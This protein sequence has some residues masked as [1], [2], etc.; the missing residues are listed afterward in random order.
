M[1]KKYTVIV[2][3]PP[4]EFGDKLSMS[5]VARGADANYSTMTI[6]QIKA[7][8]VNNIADPNGAILA[9]WVPSSLLQEGM[10]IMKAYGFN[11]KQSYIWIK[12]TKEPF[13][14]L[15]KQVVLDVKSKKG[16]ILRDALKQTILQFNFNGMFGFGMGRLF[17]QSHEVCL[18]GTNNNKIYKKLLNKSQRSVCFAPNL[19]HSA[20]PEH[21]QD[22]LDKM[23][24]GNK[25]SKIE[26]FSRRQRKNW[27][28]IGN[29]SV[30]TKNEDILVSLKKV[31]NLSEN[32]MFSINKIVSCYDEDKREDLFKM[33][34]KVP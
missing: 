1:N 15:I 18:I 27:I 7:L 31:I 4:Y 6:S 32:D 10:D 25:C 20:K 23:F 29:E 21:L 19:K 3:D 2:I 12:S 13:K 14:K 17:R 22:A 9:L 11:Q 33:W 28:C 5:D 30:M 8:P 24:D 16:K 34:G 26:I